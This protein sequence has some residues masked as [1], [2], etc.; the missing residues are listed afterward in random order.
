MNKYVKKGLCIVL[1]TG[2]IASSFAGCAKINYVT[3]GAIEAIYQI[4]DG[5]WQNQDTEDAGSADQGDVS[6]IDAFQA[7]TYGGKQFDSQDDVVNYYV[8][9]YNYTKT[10]TANYKDGGAD[11]TYYKLLGEESLAVEN[12]LI[13][14]KSNSMIDGLVPNILKGL[15]KGSTK[16]LPP[17]GSLVAANDKVGDSQ[18]DVSKSLLTPDDVLA[19]NIKDNGDGTVTLTIQPKAVISSMP[20]SDSQG[21]FFNTLGDISSTVEQISVLSFTEGTIQDNFVVDYKGG[22]GVIT[23]D[24]ATGEITK[25]EYTMLVH[26]DV[27]HASIAVIK[28]KNASLDIVY[29]NTFP[30][31]DQWLSDHDITKA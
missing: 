29:K 17:N 10:L 15:F 9:C 4:K 19:A 31:S 2:L 11:A 1:A 16:A 5:S 6:K 22:T 14:G 18:I 21:R 24:T 13:E 7:G 26:I 27:K 25:A 30:A 3:N 20:A 8:E 28:D 23:I 12:L